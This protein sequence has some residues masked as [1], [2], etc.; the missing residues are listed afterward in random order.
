[1]TKDCWEWEMLG[2]DIFW[3]VTIMLMLLASMLILSLIFVLAQSY[4]INPQKPGLVRPICIS[5]H[6]SDVCLCT[7]VHARFGRERLPYIGKV[8][9]GQFL[10]ASERLALGGF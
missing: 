5:R 1:M 9:L 8:L 4:D 3:I 2:R 6:P 7:G 10:V